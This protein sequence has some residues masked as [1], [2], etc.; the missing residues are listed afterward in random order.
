MTMKA[1][2]ACYK[3]EQI[4]SALLM[5]LNLEAQSV[6]I[7]Q[8]IPSSDGSSQF[9]TYMKTI[10]HNQI[11]QLAPEENLVVRQD[12]VPRLGIFL[13]PSLTKISRVLL[14]TYRHID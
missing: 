3:A 13:C 1:S 11:D 12:I 9:D 8:E 4:N 6:P 7:F 10:N 14:P 2:R 5:F